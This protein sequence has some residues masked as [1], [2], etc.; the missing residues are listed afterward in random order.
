MLNEDAAKKLSFIL[1]GYERR[2][3]A[4]G[5][6]RVVR[7]LFEQIIASQANRLVSITPITRDLLMRIEE[8]DVPEVQASIK[9]LMVF[10]EEEKSKE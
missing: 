4:F 8:P 2:N 6:A 9:N 1:K 10:D 5:N 3:P 7:N